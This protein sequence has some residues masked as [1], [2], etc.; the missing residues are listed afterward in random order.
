MQ[1]ESSIRIKEPSKLVGDVYLHTKDGA[2]AFVHF[3]GAT[4]VPF[5][6]A[7]LKNDLPMFSRFQYRVA[8]PDGQLAAGGE[9][10]SDFEVQM[11]KD[12]DRAGYWFA[13][14]ASL[15]IPS[16]ERHDLL[17]H[18]QRYLSWCEL[19]VDIVS[20]DAHPKV[21]SECNADSR[22]A[23]ARIL[24]PYE[25][26][27]DIKFVEVVGDNLVAVIRAGTSM[28]EHMNQDD[29]PRAFY[30][31]NAV[32]SGPTSRWLARM[33]S[34]ISHRFP[35]LSM[36]EVGA[37]T[38]ATTSAVLREIGDTYTSYTFT[39]I[40]SGFFMAAEEHFAGRAGRMVFK[41]FNMEKEPSGQGFVESAQDVVIAV[42]VL[43]VS[44]DLQTSLSNVR[45]LL[46]PGGFL[47]VGEL[48]STD[49]IFSGMTVGTLP[50]WWIGAETGRPWGPLLSLRQWDSVLKQ[51]GFSGIDTV[52][53]DISVSL[54]MNVFVAQAVND[55]ITLL[56]NPLAVNERP[57]RVRN[58][59]LAVI[60][61][62]SL[63]VYNLGQEIAQ[64]LS[65]RFQNK[66]FFDTLGDFATS[67]MAS[68]QSTDEPITVLSLV[69]LDTLYLKDLTV[70]NFAALKTLWAIAG[71]VVWVTCGTRKDNPFS[72]MMK[73]IINTV[74][75][76]YP[77]LHV[78]IYD[79][80]GTVSP[81]SGIKQNTATDL[82]VTLLR[83]RILHEWG[84]DNNLLWTSEPEILVSDGKQLI[85]RVLPDVDKNQ[86]YNSQRRDIFTKADPAQETLEL[87]GTRRGKERSIEL[88]KVSPLKLLS[89][90]VAQ[91]RTVRIRY[92]LLQSLAVV[93][94][95]FLRLCI[96]DDEVTG[97]TVL[98]LTGSSESPTKISAELCI[99]IPTKAAASTLLSVASNLIAEYSLSLTPQGSILLVNEASLALQVAL[100]AKVTGKSIGITFT[101]AEL[102]QNRDNTSVFLHLN[103]PHHVVQAKIPSSVAI[104]V[105]FSR[106]AASD[107]VRDAI[108]KCLP[109]MCL[110]ISE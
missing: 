47:V 38:G 28:L 12:V 7:T 89:P 77:N 74:K 66:Q 84:T 26:R 35:S 92:S 101:T 45:R 29:L 110:K 46:K 17:P 58:D 108:T 24:A 106:G 94:V 105:H 78:Q 67:D 104:F 40:S 54:P 34:Q 91:Y 75:T 16:E 22:E 44:G 1:Y 36:F 18:L 11:Y 76:E 93:G 6:R 14:N 9:T 64:I 96:G 90:P 97:E 72:G 57:A 33:V 41:T 87:V 61:G 102:R 86:R 65:H 5:S 103:F 50:G 99:R 20:R 109:S 4:L 25:G 37:G 42:N 69:D 68:S 79:L 19:M 80:D 48:T 43:H 62:T 32:C 49:L 52:T 85:T 39:D 56:R 3:E 100:R 53:P 71:T 73:G 82:A 27:K 10:L 15:S 2:H 98:T 83:E 70:A 59:G 13:R 81:G 51:A 60:G 63:P 21:K 88:R 23:I 30:E 95:G 55:Q 107:T 31:E 8:S